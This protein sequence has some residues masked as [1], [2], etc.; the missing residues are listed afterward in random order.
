MFKFL[1]KNH[2]H[3]PH[4]PHQVNTEGSAKVAVIVD[5]TV[6]DIMQAPKEFINVFLQ[7][8]IFIECTDAPDVKIGSTYSP[9]TGAFS[10]I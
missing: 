5:N 1:K 10:K 4:T 9:E 8:P 3:K 2:D 7:N 6:K